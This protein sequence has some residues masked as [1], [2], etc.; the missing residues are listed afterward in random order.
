M[1]IYT[2][3][4][5]YVKKTLCE[6]MELHSTYNITLYTIQYSTVSNFWTLFL[7]VNVIV[8]LNNYNNN[9]Y[10]VYKRV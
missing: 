6:A 8:Y 1:N 10:T 9:R 7:I 5:L 2:V 3:Y 4:T